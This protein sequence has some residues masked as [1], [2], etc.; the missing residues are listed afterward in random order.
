MPGYGRLTEGYKLP[1]WID[2]G[3]GKGYK[4]DDTGTTYP[5]CLRPEIKEALVRI[6]PL[7]RLSFTERHLLNQG[8]KRTRGLSHT[9]ERQ[10]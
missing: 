8:P 1:N 10:P 9:L 2:R 4:C 5:G 3:I 7:Q 6:L